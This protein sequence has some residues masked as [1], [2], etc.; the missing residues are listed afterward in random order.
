[1]QQILPANKP[2]YFRL[3]LAMLTCIAV[4]M[5]GVPYALYAQAVPDKKTPTI[6]A[7][8]A[9][10][11]Q[12]DQPAI[13]TP[14]GAPS[15]MIGGKSLVS[16]ADRPSTAPDTPQVKSLFFTQ[17]EI[18]SMRKALNVY[19]KVMSGEGESNEAMDFL[20]RLQGGDKPK[21][22]VRYFVYPQFHL[23]SLVYNNSEDWSVRINKQKMTPASPEGKSN[24]KV[25]S[26]D[27]DKI[28]VEWIPTDMQKVVE[29][30]SVAPTD[31]IEVNTKSNL[32]RF[33]L[34]PNQTFSSY[35]MRVLEGKVVPMVIDLAKGSDKT[36]AESIDKAVP[37]SA[38]SNLLDELM[39]K[40]SST[41]PSKK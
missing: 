15:V 6:A 9:G 5:S 8:G 28:T 38:D 7:G 32:V 24:I 1:M 14:A 20:R 11:L 35:V 39:G 34:R 21:A 29:V 3:F 4:V 41:L 12:P 31:T 26:V 25:T 33:T 18:L 10:V 30:W 2:A 13:E 19:A 37:K 16:R 17:E 27:K 22:N 40:V 23:E 36:A